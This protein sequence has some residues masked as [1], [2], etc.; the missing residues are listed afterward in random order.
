MIQNVEIKAR[1][2]DPRH[3]RDYLLSNH[4]IFKGT[5]T[6]RDTYFNVPNGRMKLRQGKIENALIH[7]QRSDQ[8]G[9]KSSE[10][11]LYPVAESNLL[12]SLLEKALGIKVI[13]DK[14]REIYFIENVKFHIDIVSKLGN[15]VEIEAISNEGKIPL[16][17]LQ[18]QCNFY[19]SVLGVDEKDLLHNSYS[20]QL[21]E[22]E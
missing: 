8:K 12:R 1:C 17:K 11:T 18:E 4:A 21:L 7:Y 20:D 5:D 22:T 13:V 19:M 6:Q 9:P 16:E 3:I 2:E 15:F 14:V 10:V